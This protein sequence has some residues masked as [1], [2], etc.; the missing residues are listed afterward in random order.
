MIDIPDGVYLISACTL[1]RTLEPW[2][3]AERERT[4]IK[5][6]WAQRSAATPGFFNGRVFVMVAGSCV[7]DR[8][9][10]HL[11]ATDFASSLYWRETGYRDHSVVDCFG[12]ALLIASD[13]ALIYGRQAPGNVNSG[14]IYPPGGFIDRNDVGDDGRIDID[15]SI[16]REIGEETRLDPAQFKR[17]PGYMVTRDGPHLSVGIIHRVPEPAQLLIDQ[18][19]ARLKL[20]AAPELEALIALHRKTDL[21]MHKMPGYARRLAEALLEA[22]PHHSRLPLAARILLN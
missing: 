9:E 14:M 10:G 13:G 4:A 17:D 5:R 7:G 18:I 1:R 8:L 2:A 16:I 12:S 6:H 19:M 20:E 11:A 22:Q 21:G 3:F 15:G